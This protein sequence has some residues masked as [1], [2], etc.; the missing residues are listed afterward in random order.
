MLVPYKNAGIYAKLFYICV[1]LLVHNRH[2]LLTSPFQ[3]N[4]KNHQPINRWF[5]VDEGVNA[6]VAFDFVAHESACLEE[7]ASHFIRPSNELSLSSSGGYA[8]IDMHDV[9]A[10]A[11]KIS[12]VEQGGFLATGPLFSSL[13]SS[14]SPLM[15][16]STGASVA[17]Y[18]F[19]SSAESA[20]TLAA[21]AQRA[22]HY[23]EV[24]PTRI[25]ALDGFNPPLFCTQLV[26]TTMVMN[27]A[28]PPMVPDTMHNMFATPKTASLFTL[29]QSLATEPSFT[30]A[31]WSSNPYNSTA[32]SLSR[33]SYGFHPPADATPALATPTQRALPNRMFPS[34]DFIPPPFGTHHVRPTMTTGSTVP[35]VTSDATDFHS[36]Y[37]SNDFTHPGWQ[38]YQTSSHQLD[39][40]PHMPIDNHRVGPP[41]DSYAQPPYMDP[42]P[43]QCLPAGQHSE[44]TSTPSYMSH[45]ST[46]SGPYSGDVEQ[47]YPSISTPPM[48]PPAYS[49]TN[50][51][52]LNSSPPFVVESQTQRQETVTDPGDQPFF[53]DPDFAAAV[54][55]DDWD[56]AT[57][58]DYKTWKRGQPTN[59]KRTQ[60][61]GVRKEGRKGKE[62][63]RRRAAA[64][65][66]W[67]SSPF[68]RTPMA[69]VNSY[70][71]T[72]ETNY[73]RPNP[74]SVDGAFVPPS[75]STWASSLTLSDGA[76]FGH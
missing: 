39:F 12:L 69:V 15:T 4:L 47:Y 38:P 44:Y 36:G 56:P 57:T 58:S 54:L 24:R 7:N 23:T 66:P 64:D 21:L 61:N 40:E 48:D 41:T 17:P 72:E 31:A 27:N 50:V 28:A 25:P 18:H 73:L 2:R 22:W 63:V 14:Y 46:S 3:A 60:R 11:Q 32:S 43:P 20:A 37:Q 52:S 26:P 62:G 65:K 5:D 67:L 30:S 76:V 49:Q 6:E 75:S 33:G 42:A 59:S 8:T 70:P 13:A 34:S 10:T 74:T 1:R 71:S 9:I 53:L 35:P 51:Q 45:S 29:E 19:N 16:G 68:T 55:A